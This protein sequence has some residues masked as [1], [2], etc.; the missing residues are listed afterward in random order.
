MRVE[1]R[2]SAK[3]LHFPGRWNGKIHFERFELAQLLTLGT[4]SFKKNVRNK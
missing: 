1:T 2:K 4:V 3:L